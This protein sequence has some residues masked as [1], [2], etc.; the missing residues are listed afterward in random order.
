MAKK[1]SSIQSD[2]DDVAED[3]YK[4]SSVSDCHFSFFDQP[5]LLLQSLLNSYFSVLEKVY[6]ILFESS[7]NAVYLRLE[8]FSRV[9]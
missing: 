9:D 2:T 7:K 4:K 5:K 3:N 6:Q 1:E 8:H